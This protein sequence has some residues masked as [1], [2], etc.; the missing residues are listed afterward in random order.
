M[1]SRDG[2]WGRIEA[3]VAASTA[4]PFAITR[5][6]SLGGGCI[7]EACL[8]EGGGRRY[9]VK[10]NRADRAEMFAAEAEGLAEILATK[11]IRVP[12]PVCHG[13]DGGA[14]WL[15]LEYLELGGRGDP[16]EL[17]RMLAR[18]HRVTGRGFGWRRDNTIGSTPQP[19]TPGNDWIAFW[20]EHR[21]GFQLRLAARNGLRGALQA[22]GERLMGRLESFF[23][24]YSPAPS[25]LHGDLWGGN[26]GYMVSGEPV[27]FDPAVYYGDREADLAMTELF[28]GFPSAFYAAYAEA[29]PLD[30]GY[31][32]RKQLY[33]LYHLLNHANLFG[34]G[35]PAQAES[36]MERLLAQA[37][38]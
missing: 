1:S 37:G 4:T 29:W 8:V 6:S 30:S 13:A 38:A 15:V 10:L 22:R 2:T 18:M 34:G 11:T 27:V 33:N 7:N 25:L 23:R 12:E 24:D 17:G 5:R 9:F 32:V 35:Y 36:V 19:N 28:G 20:R 16:R 14:S 3:Q 26:H 31:A 21:L